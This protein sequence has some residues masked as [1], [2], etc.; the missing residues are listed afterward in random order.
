MLT[1][2]AAVLARR[3]AVAG[4]RYLSP[5]VFGSSFAPGRRIPVAST[6]HL[7]KKA[8]K[9]QQQDLP[10]ATVFASAE[11]EDA[12]DTVQDVLSNEFIESVK[13]K[14]EAT[15]SQL[16]K[17]LSRMRGSRVTAEL[18]DTVKV[19]AY[20]RSEP[21]SSVAQVS[22]KSATLIEVTCFDPQLAT[23]VAESLK[24]MEGFS[25][26]P[27]SVGKTGKLNVPFPRPSAEAREAIA[28][29]AHQAV[30][31]S[32]QRARRIRHKALDDLKRDSDALPKDD[33]RRQASLI[34]KVAED[35]TKRLTA[36]G[37]KK[38]LDLLQSS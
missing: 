4:R 31:Q 34:D 32:R 14:L 35:A 11:E 15:T 27:Q 10:M 26:N 38:K 2:Y 16:E 28:K 21:L 23:A 1:R 19:E 6:R 13:A 30:E 22:I 25:L 36:L 7:A 17:H 8:K 20:G 3:Q 37:D 24:A 33:V 18:F 12:T 5:Q 9:K 29:A